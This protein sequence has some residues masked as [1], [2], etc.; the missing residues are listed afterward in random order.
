MII[1]RNKENGQLMFTSDKLTIIRDIM[2]YARKWSSFKIGKSG[3]TAEE[4][5]SEPDYNGIYNNIMVVYESPS[6]DN[7][8]KMEAS[9]IDSFKDNE[10]CENI[11]DGDGSVND[12][13]TTSSEYIVYVVYKQ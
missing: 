2:D 9:L 13:M 7:V 11:K 4:R 8:S 5:F 6:A 12:N 10:K 3:V 1:K